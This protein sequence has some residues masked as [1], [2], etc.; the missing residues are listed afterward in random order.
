MEFDPGSIQQLLV[1]F[2]LVCINAFFAATEMAIV[3]VNKN[4]VNTLAEKG[5]KQAIALTKI[6]GDPN[7]FL[8]TIQVGITLAGFL[9]SAFAASNMSQPLA[10]IFAD[11]G[12]SQATAGTLAIIIITVILSYFTLVFGE[13]IPK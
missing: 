12:V 1:I 11:M 3:S 13:L 6:M 2:I 9:S 10:N 5:N 7:K 8:S 4:K